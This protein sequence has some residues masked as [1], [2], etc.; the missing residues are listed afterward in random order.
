MI[1]ARRME[2]PMLPIRLETGF[3]GKGLE[4]SRVRKVVGGNCQFFP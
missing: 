3:G 4:I 2:F 1:E